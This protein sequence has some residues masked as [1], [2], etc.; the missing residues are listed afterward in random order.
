MSFLIDPFQLFFV[1][2]VAAFAIVN[3]NVL[4]NILIC[5]I[6]FTF[7]HRSLDGIQL[8]VSLSQRRHKLHI[9]LYNF[10]D[11]LTFHLN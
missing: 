6:L 2:E 3:N 8:L 9:D 7:S 11:Y 5:K 1:L 10:V 4:K